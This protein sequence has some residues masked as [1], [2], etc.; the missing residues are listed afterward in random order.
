MRNEFQSTQSEGEL[1]RS[2]FHSTQREVELMRSEVKLKQNEIKAYSQIKMHP[3]KMLLPTDI[4][5][6][7]Y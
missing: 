2:E 3:K 7:I 1:M 6:V 4:N 5:S